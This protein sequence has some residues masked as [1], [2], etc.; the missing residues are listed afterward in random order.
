MDYKSKLNRLDARIKWQFK[1]G[2]KEIIEI[3]VN[4]DIPSAWERFMDTEDEWVRL[5]LV[6]AAANVT[7]FL[8]KPKIG[9][10]FIP[11]VHPNHDETIFMRMGG[12]MIYTPNFVVELQKNEAITIPRGVPHIFDFSNEEQSLMEV[13]YGAWLAGCVFE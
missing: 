8:Y 12:A 2:F 1:K 13:N 11:H 4:V 5:V 3:N 7:A 9:S 10:T 6:E